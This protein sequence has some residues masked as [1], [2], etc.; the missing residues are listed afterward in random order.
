MLGRR[1]VQFVEVLYMGSIIKMT[2]HE[3]YNLQQKYPQY[4]IMWLL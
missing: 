4:S 2:L 1:K 3:F